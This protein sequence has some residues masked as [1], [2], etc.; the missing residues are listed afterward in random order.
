MN[1]YDVIE[2]L[3]NELRRLGASDAAVK[4]DEEF[5]P[6]AGTLVYLRVGAVYWHFLPGALLPLLQSLPNK[7]GN[8]AIKRVIERNATAVW[9]GPSPKGSR[10]TSQ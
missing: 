2:Q 6:D 1:E 10:D 4:L 5:E 9:H 7:A 8:E 3:D